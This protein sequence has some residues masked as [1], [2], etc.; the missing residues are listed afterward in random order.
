ME[1][2]EIY[3]C[4]VFIGGMMFW[5]NYKLIEDDADSEVHFGTF[6]FC[7][8]MSWFTVAWILGLLNKKAN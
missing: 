5:F 3:W 1:L 4:G 6:L 2:L 8:F 7:V